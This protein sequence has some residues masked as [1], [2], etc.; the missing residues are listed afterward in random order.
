MISLLSGSEVY[1]AVLTFYN[2]IKF[3]VSKKIIF[4]SKWFMK[5]SKKCF[6]GRSKSKKEVNIG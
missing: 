5:N 1:P 2:Y 4:N 3:L 6:Q